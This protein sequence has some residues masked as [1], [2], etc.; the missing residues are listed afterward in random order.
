M[1]PEIIALIFS[2]LGVGGTLYAALRDVKGDLCR[3]MDEIK[4]AHLAHLAEASPLIQRFV[5][6]E[7][8]LELLERDYRER[9]GPASVQGEFKK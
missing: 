6:V 7:T 1:D 3:R 8:R 5:A 2:I 4:V 9:H